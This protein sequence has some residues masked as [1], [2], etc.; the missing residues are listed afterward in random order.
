MLKRIVDERWF[1][2]KAVVGFWPAARVGDDVRL[3]AD[4]SRA[5]PIATLH[6]LRQQ[7]S[8]RDGGPIWRSPISR[9]RFERRQRLC[10][11][12]RRHGRAEEAKIAERFARAN[13]DYS[14]ILVKALADRRA[15][16]FADRC[17]RASAANSGPTRR[18]KPSAQGTDR[19][20]LWGFAPLPAI[21]RGPTTPKRRPVPPARRRAG[22]RGEGHRELRH[23]AGFIGVGR[24]HRPPQAHYFGVAK[25]ERD[26]VEDYAARKGMAVDEV[27]RWLAPVLNSR[28][29]PP[30]RRNSRLDRRRSDGNSRGD[31]RPTTA[32]TYR[33]CGQPTEMVFTAALPPSHQSFQSLIS[34]LSACIDF[35]WRR[36]EGERSGRRGERRRGARVEAAKPCRRLKLARRL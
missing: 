26:Q 3:Y 34:S 4:E 16:A 31:A 19:G 15:E 12:I 14:S 28:P 32:I 21:R 9:V 33:R 8:R 11:R 17:I 35:C 20:A 27:E 29:C 23:V 24:L 22:D 10:R 25:M 5:A 18:T 30:R 36:R 1:A 2:P 13:D 6:T 7:L